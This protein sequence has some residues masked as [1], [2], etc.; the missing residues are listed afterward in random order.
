[1]ITIIV[2]FLVA[3][4][5]GFR[6]SAGIMEWLSVM[7]I[8]ALFTLA[9][10]WVAVIPGLT[11]KTAEGASVFS[12]PLIFLPMFSSAFAP[13]ET[14]PAA[15]RWF[16]ENQPVTAI[17]ETVRALLN[18]ETVG[19][20]IWVALGWCVGIMFVAWFIAMKLYK[21]NIMSC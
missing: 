10:T 15:V 7:G 5:M 21:R 11:A 13:T 8:L 17:V 6:T 2:I 12:Y 16:A 3:L 9:L 20:E 4:V 14:M 1:M 18:G 19:N